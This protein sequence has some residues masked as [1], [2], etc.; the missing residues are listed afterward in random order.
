MKKKSKAVLIVLVSIFIIAGGVVSVFLVNANRNE[1]AR[2][3]ISDYLNQYKPEIS[4]NTILTGRIG[5]LPERATMEAI[6]RYSTIIVRGK[7]INIGDPFKND[8]GLIYHKVTLEVSSVLKGNEKVGI[9]DDVDVVVFGGKI[10]NEMF[11]TEDSPHFDKD[12]EVI[13]FLT[14][15]E[16]I[17]HVTFEAY[18]KIGI[19]DGNTAIGIDDARG[20]FKIPVGDYEREVK[21]LV[22]K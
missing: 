22:Q 2:Q 1:R 20:V 5:L 7:V 9:G 11:W 19:K 4:E 8:H 10:D 21:D 16:D 13:V 14:W 6:Q 12:E 3:E 17:Y 18:G 15:G